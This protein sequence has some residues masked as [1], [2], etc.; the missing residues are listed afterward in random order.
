MH[1]RHITNP[2]G[3][4]LLLP[5]FPASTRVRLL[6]VRLSHHARLSNLACQLVLTW[7]RW[8]GSPQSA[9]TN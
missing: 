5:A 4:L 8:G 1:V 9:H 3:P 7:G 2:Y 6:P